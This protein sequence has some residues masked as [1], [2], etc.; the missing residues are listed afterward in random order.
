MEPNDVMPACRQCPSGDFEI[1]T[2]KPSRFLAICHAKNCIL[3]PA[4]TDSKISESAYITK[5]NLASVTFTPLENCPHL[6]KL[7]LEGVIPW[8]DTLI[9][10]SK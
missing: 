8:A 9:D 5:S 3:H 7:Q 10:Y 6:V 2:A 1:T 4:F